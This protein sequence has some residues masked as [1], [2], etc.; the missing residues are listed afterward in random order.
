M[1][2]VGVG[3][4]VARERWDALQNRDLPVALV[5]VGASVLL[6]KGGLGGGYGPLAGWHVA[7]ALVNW[8]DPRFVSAYMALLLALAGGWRGLRLL[9]P[10]VPSEV[11]QRF[12][13]GLLL[14]ILL[15]GAVLLAGGPAVQ[16][17]LVLAAL[18][19]VTCG[20]LAQA[21]FRETS[22]ARRERRLSGRKLAVIL[23][24]IG[25]P[26][27]LTLALAGWFSADVAALIAR[28][29]E[30]LVMA[31]VFVITPLV[32]AFFYVFEA[33][34]RFV[35][36]PSANSSTPVFPTPPTLPPSLQQQEGA[37]T[38][39]P[40][41][42]ESATHALVLLVP[43]AILIVLFF[44]RPRRTRVAAAG[45]EE[46]ES[47]WSWQAAGQDLRA[48]WEQL[49]HAGQRARDPL[50]AAL[51]RLRGDDPATAIRRMYVRLLMRGARMGHAR[52]AGQTPAEY[53]R[54]LAP[55]LAAQ[56]EAITTL[57]HS[58]ERA[59]YH[60]EAATNMDA[61]AAAQAWQQIADAA[62]Q[63]GEPLHDGG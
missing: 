31:F 34:V 18:C 37:P 54:A 55:V 52:A 30:A 42:L 58:Y 24:A 57:T 49:R 7:A 12:K 46:R 48:W 63:H 3:M 17:M 25:V 53:A 35:R 51:A 32:T 15:I 9:L 40:P 29:Y 1:L 19:Y 47:V 41:W 20:L 43:L 39:F 6:V 21:F 50:A 5:L 23:A 16:S 11:Q 45:D 22:A 60:P 28:A 4:A 36:G 8:N 14:L 61:A 33:L 62:A 44:R 59:R 27:V 56:Q 38:A 10:T 13:R 2:L 26:L